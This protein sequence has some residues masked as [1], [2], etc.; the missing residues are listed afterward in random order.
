MCKTQ[1]MVNIQH[2]LG[3]RSGVPFKLHKTLQN[4]RGAAYAA[5]NVPPLGFFPG[6]AIGRV[7]FGV[8][9]LNREFEGPWTSAEGRKF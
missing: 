1:W 7:L 3:A 5:F 8:S 2:Q 6:K 9:S 4:Q